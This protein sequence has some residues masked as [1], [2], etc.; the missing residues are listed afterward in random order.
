MTLPVVLQLHALGDINRGLHFNQ[1]SGGMWERFDGTIV[2][3]L[4]FT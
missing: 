1:Q 4:L 3:C 2:F